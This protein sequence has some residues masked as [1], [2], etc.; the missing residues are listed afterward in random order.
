MDTQSLIFCGSS[1]Q[2][3]GEEISAILKV[4]LGNIQLSQF[5]DK[6]ISIEILERV[7]GRNVFVIQSIALDPNFYLMELLIIVDALKR[8]SA[9]NI[10]A[11]IPY[12][13]Y[14]RQDRKDKP[15][16]PITAKLIANMLTAAGITHLVTFDLHASQLEGFFEIPVTHLH[17]Q[18]LLVDFA[19]PLLGKDYL[20]IAPDIGSIKRAEKVAKLMEADFAIIEKRRISS[21]DVKMTLIGTLSAKNILIADDIC[22][23]A[24]TLVS[25]AKLCKEH[26]AEKIIATVTHGVCSGNAIE[27]IEN[28]PLNHLI[29][30][31]TIPFFNRF[32]S[33][34]KI[35]S[36]SVAP[37]IANEIKKMYH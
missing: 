18:K 36:T 7:Q 10:T 6:E 15:G 30:T 24:N 9:K 12:F 23:T 25:A 14:C 37:L 26:G 35:L 20:V 19:L 17:C 27:Q 8:A 21:M 32:N 2:N 11:I 28:S 29:V 5:P 31:N 22:S 13:G 4:P 3:L 33:S 16:V 1:H 34:T